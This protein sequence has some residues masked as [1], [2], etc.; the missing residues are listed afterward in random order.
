MRHKEYYFFNEKLDKEEYLKRASKYFSYEGNIKAA[1]ESYSHFLKYPKKYAKIVNSENAVGEDIKNSKNAVNVFLA[2]DVENGKN[3]YIVTGL[4][5]SY[6]CTSYAWGEF[7]YNVASSFNSSRSFC[8]SH[9]GESP[10]CIYSFMIFNSQDCFGCVG[11]IKKQYCIFNKQ[12]S[13]EEYE[14]LVPKI[15]EHMQKTGEWGEFFPYSISPFG[16]NETMAMHY[17]PLKKGDALKLG[18]KWQD[19]DYGIQYDGPFYEPKDIKQYDPNVNPDAEK[20]IEECKKGILKC[21]VTGKPYRIFPQEL[22]AYIERGIQIPRKHP[23]QR[24]IERLA[25]LNPRRLHHRQCMCEGITN[26]EL[27]I[28]NGE[29]KTNCSHEGRCR[30][31]FETTYAPDRPEKLYCEDC[32]QKIVI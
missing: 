16:Y 10:S 27:R 1:K 31:E 18:A 19:N 6:D 5:E 30:N 24:N 3:H 26:D 25:R 4:N 28:T 14:E 12:Y 17:Y 22:A 8:S 15:I 13:K 9:L 32:Y 29:N 2:D 23:D 21:E 20:E 7:L 11:L